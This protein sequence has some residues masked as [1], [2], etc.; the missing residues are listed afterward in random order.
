MQ[1]A[2]KGHSRDASSFEAIKLDSLVAIFA[3]SKDMKAK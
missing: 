2:F 3:K 1:I